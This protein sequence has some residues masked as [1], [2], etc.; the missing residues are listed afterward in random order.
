MKYLILLLLVGCGSSP[1]MFPIPG[2]SGAPGPQGLPGPQGEQGI[3]G[4]PGSVNIQICPHSSPTGYILLIDNIP[5]LVHSSKDK[6]FV[7]QMDDVEVKYCQV[8]KE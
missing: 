5:F 1:V 8:V 4:E 3:Q 6:V 7:S 2:P